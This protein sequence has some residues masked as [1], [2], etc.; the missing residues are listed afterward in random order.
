M[1]SSALRIARKTDLS[2]WLRRGAPYHYLAG[3]ASPA[4]G[5][6]KMSDDEHV[7]QE[8]LT[9]PQEEEEGFLEEEEKREEAE[10]GRNSG[11]AEDPPAGLLTDD[12]N[13]NNEDGK[14]R[15]R[16]SDEQRTFMRVLGDTD[17][18]SDDYIS[19]VESKEE[20][21]DKEEE[22]V[23]NRE[24]SEDELFGQDET[25]AK[26]KR[27]V[28]SDRKEKMRI[29]FDIDCDSDYFLSESE[30]KEEEEV[31]NRETSEDELF[32]QD[33]T[34]AE[35]KRQVISVK[36]KV[37]MFFGDTD[38]D[39]DDFLFESESEQEEEGADK[40]TSEDTDGSDGQSEDKDEREAERETPRDLLTDRYRLEVLKG[41][42]DPASPLH[43][44]LHDNDALRVIFCHVDDWRFRKAIR[45][46]PCHGSVPFGHDCFS[47]QNLTEFP[48]GPPEVNPEDQWVEDEWQELVAE[49]LICWPPPQDLNINMMPFD[50]R[51]PN[52]TLPPDC[53]P[54]LECLFRS[55]LKDYFQELQSSEANIAYLTIHEGKVAKDTSQRRPG[56]HTE[57][58]GFVRSPCAM[59]FQYD[60]LS[61][62]GGSF[63]GGKR[64]GGI[65]MASNV[66][67]STKVWD[68]KIRKPVIG[69][70]GDIEH[71]RKHLGDGH[72]MEPDK[73]YWMTDTTPHESLPMKEDTYRQYVRLVVGK[74]TVWYRD[75]STPN[76]YGVQP[77]AVILEGDKFQ[78]Q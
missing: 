66:A 63:V 26:K 74:V 75:H 58:P 69:K 20:E 5:A 21:K 33:E 4:R 2:G 11:S 44:L 38:C 67:E 31:A 8:T 40:E 47:V 12:Q 52:Q 68:V 30:A 50:L 7:A 9:N 18:H 34:K 10:M 15:R 24:T 46:G 57:S 17:Y 55:A 72:F 23:A 60:D 28:I 39:S 6:C 29:L 43:A 65:Y 32:G 53:L 16:M 76:P 56:L 71:L 61:W 70:L 49:Q 25:K 64:T 19:G 54:Y 41:T 51:R 59:E 3:G 77:D 62:G 1:P 22:E 13:E 73:L 48:F 35:K 78:D 45:H 14:R 36:K 27:Q 42:R 37:M